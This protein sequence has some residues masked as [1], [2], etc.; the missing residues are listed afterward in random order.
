ME[1]FYYTSTDTMNKIL[2]NGNI[3][4]TN[5]RY[6][7]DSEEYINGMEEI[8]KLA[9]NTGLVKK[10][11]QERNIDKGIMRNIQKLFTEDNLKESMQ[12]MEY[13]SISF[14]KKN[15]LLSQWAIYAKESGVSIKM[16]F[17]DNLYHFLTKGEND[18]NQAEWQLSPQEVY[19]FTLESMKGPKS[20]YN[21]VAYKILDQ[22]YET[23]FRDL[24]DWKKERWR[25]IST[26]VKRYD[27]Y[28]EEEYRLVFDPN[29]S[30]YAPCVQ[31]RH[32]HKILKPYL[33]IECET[34][35]P[36][37][38]I[39]IGPGFNQQVVY[40]S[41]EHL[42][43]HAKVKNG[44]KTVGDYVKRINMYLNP[45]K[46]DLKMCKAYK[47]LKN[48]ILQ[49]SWIKTTEFESATIFLNQ[50][51]R[52]IEHAVSCVEDEYSEKVKEYFMKRHFTASGIV[53]TKSNIP[54]IF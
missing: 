52:E 2:T 43:N 45:Y 39:M 6:M 19:Y 8:Y 11:M 5:I 49:K 15:D 47:E 50:K 24:D 31:Y 27:F 33:N 13:Y 35:W 25:Y 28:Q 48:Q 17:E 41:I 37:W 9:Q 30:T 12:K 40:D 53:L 14:C 23:N 36:I 16:N 1:L 51:M 46:E 42:L 4:A 44:I 38:E 7:N 32:D 22:L 21:F 3:Y 34:G 26:L 10:W 18:V 54:Y 20:D 29:E